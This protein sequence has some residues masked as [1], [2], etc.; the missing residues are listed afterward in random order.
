MED[1]IVRQILK[2]HLVG[3][4]ITKVVFLDRWGKYVCERGHIKRFVVYSYHMIKQKKTH[5]PRD[6]HVLKRIPYQWTS[7]ILH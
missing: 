6:H 5:Q 2:Y 7:G 1:Q 3:E 4:G